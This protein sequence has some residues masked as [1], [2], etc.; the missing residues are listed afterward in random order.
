MINYSE[1]QDLFRLISQYLNKDVECYAFGGTAMMFYGYKDQTKDIDLLFEEE[2][3]RGEFIRVLTLLGFAETS[4]VKVYPLKKQSD[5]HSPL[6]YQRGDSRFDLFVKKFFHTI[7]SPKMKEE[8]YAVHQ[9]KGKHTLSIKVLKREIIVMLKAVTD[10]EKD[11][12]DSLNIIKKTKDFNWPDL[13]E[14]VL[15]QYHHGDRWALLDMEKI[16]RELKK[17]VFVEE[18]Y[19]RQLYSA[20]K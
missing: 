4:P 10:R 1:Q 14:E 6:M 7:I 19:L 12:E 8:I 11:F 5:P 2:T 17:Y 13:I 3:A 16:L 15:W 9:F 20:V 18:K